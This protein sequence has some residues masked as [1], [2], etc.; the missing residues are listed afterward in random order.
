[1]DVET[2]R[3][4]THTPFVVGSTTSRRKRSTREPFLAGPIPMW[5]LAE[6]YRRGAAAQAVGLALWHA[7]GLQRGRPGPIKVNAGTRRPMGLSPDQ[8]RRGVRSLEAAGLVTVQRGGRGRCAVV[9]I[10]ESFTEP[11]VV[12]G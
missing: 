4:N 7:R 12:S 10:V 11:G 5:W 3:M 9:A 1:M 8:A 6:A 2:F